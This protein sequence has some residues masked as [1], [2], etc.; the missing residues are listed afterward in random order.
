MMTF[1]YRHSSEPNTLV[2]VS[3]SEE[4]SL[5]EACEAFER[6]LRASTYSFDSLEEHVTPK[7]GK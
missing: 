7:E 1:T 3:I 2:T 4:S 5:S 6:F